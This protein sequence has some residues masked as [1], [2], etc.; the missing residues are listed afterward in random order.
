M[1]TDYFGLKVA[2]VKGAGAFFRCHGVGLGEGRPDPFDDPGMGQGEV[3]NAAGNQMT[4]T[5]GALPELLPLAAAR[6]LREGGAKG[7]QG[8][9]GK[10]VG[11]QRLGAEADGQNKA[12][13]QDAEGHGR[14]LAGE[15]RKGPGR[16]MLSGVGGMKN[17][18]RVLWQEVS[19]YHGARPFPGRHPCCRKDLSMTQGQRLKYSILISLLVLGAMLGLSWLQKQGVISEQVFQYVAIAIAV[20]VVVI[21]GIMRR[22]VKP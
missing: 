7:A 10:T 2:T 4:A 16:G 6:V 5:A 19:M 15:G 14:V 13:E 21:N 22:K 11:G 20:V 9:F 8:A 17:R 1:G 18:E 3:R 12:A